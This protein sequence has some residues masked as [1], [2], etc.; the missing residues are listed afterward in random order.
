[1]LNKTN[2][3]SFFIAF[4]VVFSACKSDDDNGYIAL[5]ITTESDMTEVSKLAT[6]EI[7]IF[8]NDA[9][10]PQ[11]G[12]LSVTSPTNGTVV[13]NNNNT[14][15]DLRDDFI[16]YDPNEN[17]VGSDSFQYTICLMDGSGCKVETVSITVLNETIVNLDLARFPYA[18]LSEYNFFDGN[19][20]DITAGYGVLKYEPIN[21]LF[22]DYAIKARYVWIP[23]GERASYVADNK[24]LD[25]PDGSALIKV[26]SYDNVLPTNTTRIM[27]TRVMVKI[28]SEWQFAEYIWN[29]EQTEGFLDDIG[30][31]GFKEIEW[32]QN[33]EPMSV[34]Y[35][36]PAMTQCIICHSNAGTTVPL[37]I[38]PQSINTTIDYSDGPS[39]QL[40]KLIDFG[41]L[42]NSIPSTI[43]TAVNWSDASQPVELRMR[44]Y[45]DMNCGNCHQDGGSGDFRNIRLAFND[46]ETNLLESII[47]QDADTPIPGLTGQ[48]LIS[49]RDIDNSIIYYRMAEEEG[50]YKMPQ[51]GQTLVHTEGL[52]LMEE[53]INS[54]TLNCD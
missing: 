34:N 37:G 29:D 24:S 49:P 19:L 6:I 17:F 47:C 14:P 48:K 53:W 38:K 46:T 11:D 33:G 40:Q 12:T 50:L 4:L 20:S 21:P 41:Y 35:R 7:Q 32:L 45:V 54:L 8:S 18:T 27:E 22:T 16:L 36:F 23:P 42:E 26:F 39:N 10:I 1:M 25:F 51:F 30:D 9:N 3:F 13:V 2:A 44:S 43:N 5:E 15:S 28:D 31:G 52:A